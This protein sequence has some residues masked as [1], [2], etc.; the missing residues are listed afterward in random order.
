MIRCVVISYIISCKNVCRLTAQWTCISHIVS[1]PSSSFVIFTCYNFISILVHNEEQLDLLI[2]I[3]FKI[4]NSELPTSWPALFSSQPQ[5][6]QQR[7]QNILFILKWEAVVE[8]NSRCLINKGGPR[9]IK[10]VIPLYEY[11]SYKIEKII[12]PCYAA[13]NQVFIV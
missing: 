13:G 2:N 10:P 7:L 5:Q 6:K 1:K 12:I 9:H 4:N 3:F 11:S 8:E